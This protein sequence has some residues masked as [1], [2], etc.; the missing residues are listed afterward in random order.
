[1]TRKFRQ[2]KLPALVWGIIILAL[3]SYPR[4]EIPDIGFDA[5]DKVAHLGVYLVFGFLLLR[6][7][8]EENPLALRTANVRTLLF[9][10]SFAVFD[11]LHQLFI[12]G[13]SC[14]VW[15]ALAD[16]FG[17]LLGHFLYYAIIVRS[18]KR[19]LARSE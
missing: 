14:D 15:D 5:T 6:A 11:E 7:F 17:V 18:M 19:S 1:M 2:Y 13:R 16:I 12:P 9:G 3:T 8:A 10:I 4:L